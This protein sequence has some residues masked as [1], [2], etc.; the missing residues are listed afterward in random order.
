MRKNKLIEQYL[1]YAQVLYVKYAHKQLVKFRLNVNNEQKRKFFYRCG[2][3]DIN[4]Y[5]H[6]IKILLSIYEHSAHN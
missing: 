3:F 6:F 2:I 5:E 4:N 1:L